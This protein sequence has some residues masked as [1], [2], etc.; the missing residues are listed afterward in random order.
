MRWR[1]V[2]TAGPTI[3]LLAWAVLGGGPDAVSPPVLLVTLPLA[4]RRRW[5]TGSAGAC[6]VGVALAVAGYP[7]PA[8]ASLPMLIAVLISAFAVADRA[9]RAWPGLVLLITPLLPLAVRGFDFP[10]PDW[11]L[12]MALVGGVWFAGLAVRRRGEVAQA[13]RDRA[14]AEQREGIARELHDVVTHRVSVMVIQAGAARTVLVTDPGTATG[15]LL[16]LEAGGREALSELRGLLGLLAAPAR[17]DAAPP[18]GIAAVPALLASVRAAGLPVRYEV[19]GEPRPVPDRLDRTAYRI[20]QEALTNA[21]RHSSRAGTTV[22]LSYGRSALIIETIDD[23]PMPGEVGEG[24]GLV[25][26][27][28]RAA[29]VGGTVE[30]GPRPGHGFGVRAVLPWPP[31]EG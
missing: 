16:A 28:E 6:A 10:L 26:M 18:S 13:L 21:L 30:T 29:L 3:V 27:R 1:H 14:L 20:L 19:T 25:G 11:A 12:P 9:R 23:D 5:P 7:I 8:G 2:L 17:D 22:S 4:T 15:Q 31:G 24:R